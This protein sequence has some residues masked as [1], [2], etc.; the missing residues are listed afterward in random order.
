[1]LL[2]FSRL[3]QRL[4]WH[5]ETWELNSAS[6]TSSDA[7]PRLK[8]VQHTVKRIW[9]GSLWNTRT[10]NNAVGPSKHPAADPRLKVVQ[11]RRRLRRVGWRPIG[12]VHKGALL[13][14]AAGLLG[15]IRLRR[16]M[17]STA[18]DVV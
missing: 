1:M 9:P 11:G 15:R 17:Q 6:P 8:V 4:Y 3:S 2:A 12:W 14:G 10:N 16:H 7:H 5:M 13:R 18:L